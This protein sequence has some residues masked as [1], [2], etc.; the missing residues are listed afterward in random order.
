MS[1]SKDIDWQSIYCRY[2][3]GETG[4]SISKDLGGRPT[5]QAIAYRA[6]T[7]GWQRA[8]PSKGLV[9][10]NPGEVMQF[11]DPRKAVVVQEILEGATHKLAG[12]VVGVTDDTITNWKKKDAE[13]SEAITAARARRLIKHERNIDKAGDQ[14]DW[15]ASLAVLERDPMT[16][17]QYQPRQEHVGT[18]IQINVGIDRNEVKIK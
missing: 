14:G 18:A 12:A 3:D 6:K 8:K 16:K 5:K 9:T 11:D 4:H 13:F 2:V 15:K 17:G 1:Y 7:R 10:V